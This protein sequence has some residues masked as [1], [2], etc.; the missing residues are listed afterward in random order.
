MYTV[1]ELSRTTA[2]QIFDGSTFQVETM[3]LHE[4]FKIA[5]FFFRADSH[6]LT[7][8]LYLIYNRNI[9]NKVWILLVKTF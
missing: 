4:T 2:L 9:Q 8:C 6:H 3:F 7:S 1:T 5:Y